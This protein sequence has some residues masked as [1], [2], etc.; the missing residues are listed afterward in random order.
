[1]TDPNWITSPLARELEAIVAHERHAGTV[2]RHVTFI[3]LLSS[4]RGLVEQVEEGYDESVYEYANDVDSRRILGRV[5]ESASER[6]RET[7]L[8]WLRPW[9]ERFEAATVRAAAPFHGRPEPDSPHAASP[10]HWRIPRRLLG[11]LK[12][13]LEDMG[14]A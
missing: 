9:D 1:V 3:G 6:P 12:A 14:L 7:L 2:G 10:W 8:A 13:D 11:E 4:W 5:A